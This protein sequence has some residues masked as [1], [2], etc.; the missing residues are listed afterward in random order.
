LRD[1]QRIVARMSANAS[2]A[3]QKYA[4][5][6]QEKFDC[7]SQSACI[8]L[9]RGADVLS[10]PRVSADRDAMVRAAHGR[11]TRRHPPLRGV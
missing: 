6:V 3:R 5:Y 8:N 4:G 10:A 11:P 7:D 9:K 2:R 1:S